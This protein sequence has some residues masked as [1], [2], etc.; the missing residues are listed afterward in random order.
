MSKVFEYGNG[1]DV[2]RGPTAG[3]IARRHAVRVLVCLLTLVACWGDSNLTLPNDAP[4]QFV[5]L[6]ELLA[7]VTISVDGQ[8]YVILSTGRSTALTVSSAKRLTW[9][10][11]KPADADGQPIPDDIGDVQ[12]AVPGINRTL[13]ISNVIEDRT[14]I[15]ARMFNHTDARVSIGVYDGGKVACGA[16]VLPAA[17]DHSSG[18]V[19]I[20]YYRLL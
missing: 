13:E 15:T 10:S 18:F 17:A 19:Q 6:N 2:A 8:P 14:Y 3:A 20:G 11:A 5:A 16:A 12:V 1:F 9:T 4:V 7:P